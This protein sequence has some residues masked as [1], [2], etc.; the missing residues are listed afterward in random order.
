MYWAP[1][2]TYSTQFDIPATQALV[3][4]VADDMGL[5]VPHTDYNM[6]TKNLQQAVE[7]ISTWARPWK[8]R[9]NREKSTNVDFT[10]RKHGYKPIVLNGEVL[11]KANHAKYLGVYLD[12]RLTWKTH[13]IK[14]RYELNIRFRRMYWLFR[15]RNKLSLA[16]K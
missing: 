2:C 14:K 13:I 6:A 1:I 3:A 5:S 12:K 16:N 4:T 10:L 8:I 9:L 7:E 15:A 11:E